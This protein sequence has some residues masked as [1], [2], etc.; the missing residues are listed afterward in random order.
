MKPTITIT[1]N[2]KEDT[3]DRL[4]LLLQ[5]AEEHQNCRFALVT[6]SDGMIITTSSKEPTDFDRLLLA[7][8]SREAMSTSAAFHAGVARGI[9]IGAEHEY[10]PQENGNE[11]PERLLEAKRDHIEKAVTAT[12]TAGELTR[13][14]MAP[15]GLEAHPEGESIVVWAK[16]DEEDER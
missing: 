9:V 11:W 6:F 16:R 14:A 13:V 1:D 2:D 7:C 12:V 4:R 5:M 8:F 3:P 10:G 15:F